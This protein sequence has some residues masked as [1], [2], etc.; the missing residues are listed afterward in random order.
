MRPATGAVIFGVLR[1]EA[2]RCRR[3]RCRR[4]A[5][6][7]WRPTPRRS[8][9]SR[10]CATRPRFEQAFGARAL[11][12]EVLRLGRVA[13]QGRFGLLAALTSNGAGSSVNSSW[14]ARTSCPSVNSTVSNSPETCA[15]TSTVDEASTLPT[16]RTLTAI[17]LDDHRSRRHDG[18][19]RPRR[20]PRAP[21]AG[22]RRSARAPCRRSH[23]VAAST[24]SP[25]HRP[26]S[27]AQVRQ[28]L[29]ID[30]EKFDARLPTKRN[31]RTV[32]MSR[33]SPRSDERPRRRQCE[34]ARLD[35]FVRIER[36]RPGRP[37][38]ILAMIEDHQFVT[39][40]WCR[41]ERGQS[42]QPA[43]RAGR[44]PRRIRAA[45]PRAGLAG[46]QRP[47]RQLPNPPPNRV[48]V[49]AD[50]N[51]LTS[52]R[53]RNHHH[54]SAMTDH[55]Q[56]DLPPV[57]HPHAILLDVEHAASEDTTVART[58]TVRVRCTGT[59]V[60]G[61]FWRWPSPTPTSTSDAAY[62]RT[63]RTDRTRRTRCTTFVPLVPT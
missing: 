55:I 49:L 28:E 25:I 39:E 2:S 16:A 13:R 47:G 59:S 37:D 11:R 5:T 52:R 12:L 23:S 27:T 4:R 6:P 3:P 33:I 26:G 29:R 50:Q 41:I 17:G 21:P 9:R 31:P 56:G 42:R 18:R 54:R 24:P 36:D 32:F 20:P 22:G 61:T 7:G 14:P 45:P 51:D 1:A 44:F 46:F 34:D 53:L 35:L 62:L 57:R 58:L 63:S 30:A 19:A 38:Q 48:A 10:R 15:R 40:S 43:R 60:R 8:R